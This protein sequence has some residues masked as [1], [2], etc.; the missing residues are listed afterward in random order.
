MGRDQLD[1]TQDKFQED[2]SDAARSGKE[3]VEEGWEQTK[4]RAEDLGDEVTE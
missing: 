3:V 4:R 1:E 2:L